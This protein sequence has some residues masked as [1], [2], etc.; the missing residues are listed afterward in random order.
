MKLVE[1]LK[2]WFARRDRVDPDVDARREPVDLPPNA[3]ERPPG[4][5]ESGARRG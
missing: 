4:M 1:K 5:P 2:S 3:H